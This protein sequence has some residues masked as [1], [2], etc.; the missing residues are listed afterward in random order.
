[1][2]SKLSIPTALAKRNEQVEIYNGKMR[3]T[4]IKVDRGF[5]PGHKWW[6]REVKTLLYGQE[7]A[8]SAFQVGREKIN[9]ERGVGRPPWFSLRVFSGNSA[10]RASDMHRRLMSAKTSAIVGKR[11]P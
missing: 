8:M 1:M 9:R 10:D 2:D 5:I 7:M 4:K 11:L 6:Q 3:P